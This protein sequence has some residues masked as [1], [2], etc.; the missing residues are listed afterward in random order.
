MKH[1]LRSVAAWL[2]VLL[3]CVNLL[4]AS[5]F[6]AVSESGTISSSF[7]YDQPSYTI[8]VMDRYYNGDGVLERDA[9]RE[10]K[11]YKEGEEYSYDALDPLPDGYTLGSDENVS[12]IASEDMEIEF[13]YDKIT[14][15]YVTVSYSQ[16][17]CNYLNEIVQ[18]DPDYFSGY[19]FNPT[20]IVARSKVRLGEESNFNLRFSD[21]DEL[22]GSGWSSHPNIS[23]F[24]TYYY[25]YD[26]G[27]K[28]EPRYLG[29]PMEGLSRDYNIRLERHEYDSDIPVQNCLNFDFTTDFSEYIG[30]DR[31]TMSCCHLVL[32][33]DG[34]NVA[35]SDYVAG[36]YR[37]VI[38][39]KDTEDNIEGWYK[40][41][42]TGSEFS[43]SRILGSVD[44]VKNNPNNFTLIEDGTRIRVFRSHFEEDTKAAVIYSGKDK[45]TNKDVIRFKDGTEFKIDSAPLIEG[46][47][48]INPNSPRKFW[49]LYELSFEC[50]T[51]CYYYDYVPA[52]TYAITVKDKFVDES[53][54][55]IEVEGYSEIRRTDY[56]PEGES[57]SYNALSTDPI[58]GYLLVGDSILT[59]TADS[60]KEIVFTYQKQPACTIT[61]K[62]RFFDASGVEEKTDIRQ[63]DTYEYGE[64]YSYYELDPVPDGYVYLYDYD[65][66]LYGD[67]D[68][69]YET[70][71]DADGDREIIFSYQKEPGCTI[72]VRDK[73]VDRFGTEI[74]TD[75][76]CTENKY[77]GEMYE[78]DCTSYDENEYTVIGGHYDEWGD[79]VTSQSGTV[80]GDMEIVF[81][82]QKIAEAYITVSYSEALC[83]YLNGHEGNWDN[84]VF[85]PDEVVEKFKVVLGRKYGWNGD[86]YNS[87]EL[88]FDDI[89]NV[90]NSG[91]IGSLH[92]YYYTDGG[93]S[94]EYY[95]LGS[96]VDGAVS[97][98]PYINFSKSDYAGSWE[99]SYA[100]APNFPLDLPAEPDTDVCCH[101]VLDID[102]LYL[103]KDIQLR[104]VYRT[105]INS[106]DKDA[107]IES[108]YSLKNINNGWGMINL[109][110]DE[111]SEVQKRPDD[112][113]FAES[114]TILMRWDDEDE[115][116]GE[117]YDYDERF[118]SCVMDASGKI[119]SF[120][121][122]SDGTPFKVMAA[123][124][125]EDY[126]CINPE[127]PRSFE[128]IVEW[129]I[130]EYCFY[131]DY[132]YAPS[133][134]I[135]V[136][137]KF[138]DESGA[139]EKTDI[140]QTDKIPED[141]EYT[142]EAIDPIP[143]GYKLV[144]DPTV[145]GTSTEDKEVVFVYQKLPQYTI[146][147]KD[148]FTNEA[149]IEENTAIR[150]EDKL[151]EGKAYSYS[152]LNPIPE[153]YELVGVSDYAGVVSEDTEIIFT[154]RRKA[155][156]PNTYS[157][158]V[159]DKYI[160]I[161]GS[162][163]RIDE[164]VNTT[165][166]AFEEY[167]FNAISPVPEG[168]E[169]V[170]ASGYFGRIT[171]DTEI[172]FVY[173]KKP[174]EKPVSYTF[175]V[176]DEYY[177]A[178]GNVIETVE[179]TTDILEEGSEYVCTAIKSVPDGYVLI[180]DEEYRG[181]I[182]EDTVIVFKYKEVSAR[183]V[184]IKGYLMYNNGEPVANK[185]VEIH[186]TV[187]DT[188][189]DANG[190]YEIK[191]V[192]VGS[193]KFTVFNDDGTDLI[194]C[195]IEIRK[196]GQDTVSVTYKMENT[197]V[198]IDLS[199][200]DVLEIDGVLPLYKLEV[201][202]KYYNESNV[203]V[204][205]E[206]RESLS[207]VKF[208]TAY[209][210]DALSPKG[211]TVTSKKN[212]SGTV[213]KDTTVIFTYR[214][215]KTPD[216]PKPTPNPNPVPTPNPA[217]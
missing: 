150:Q 154:Y 9:T 140:R 215:D 47:K 120:G 65:S 91:I 97:K 216:K 35:K 45:N 124:E 15:A 73:Y 182:S 30:V 50:G 6:A 172:I 130:S 17:L 135:A 86:D 20:K 105:V 196:D 179:R 142:Y 207:A 38:E 155:V 90:I 113:E 60:D 195:D 144:S 44:A 131:Y 16:E 39:D 34:F 106:L 162:V 125:I 31:K 12:G 213:A 156:A 57:Y 214:K 169:V 118:V 33:M 187:R 43:N 203:L 81:T 165:L 46:Y 133:H 139:E 55:E 100:L 209:S 108:W 74:K 42:D 85:S 170:G 29:Y 78:Y 19:D 87:F 137:D 102:G 115:D 128:C 52:V 177:D 62:D 197:D 123:P 64:Y 26:R 37:T 70:S 59:G 48:C 71:G 185:K 200:A 183:F 79:L 160:D 77:L 49:C 193:H 98:D 164:R 136:K 159:R 63:V 76:R 96:R 184:T 186:S 147:V 199:V 158:I 13:R 167:V 116:G 104:G 89:S 190:Y 121:T 4:P 157:M 189:T 94:S 72:T 138:I 92:S 117:I 201:I 27:W 67:E 192:E 83:D 2:L 68:G 198:K 11:S 152:T 151:Y 1:K 176:I 69:Y 175:K 173:Q 10:E 32:G 204:I 178:D 109:A 36:V 99:L 56:V 205:S 134:K 14:E 80:T 145:T 21:L 23:S 8:K 161:D 194:T 88:K 112:F 171:S 202:D 126:I 127:S 206:V 110:T 180:S 210:Y 24:R 107:R 7:T 119:I 66:L 93:W 51:R 153:G 25:D 191:N 143:D 95:Y 82:Y 41:V 208:G 166:T 58:E 163:I 101:I 28:A 181:I 149:G 174:V 148:V 3:Q 129:D 5:A 75:I 22:C 211:Y 132:I 168:Y 114:G 54:A 103:L 40:P 122:K 188:V 84:H 18:E 217:Y 61:I 146:T 53:G 141:E 212:Y 111:W